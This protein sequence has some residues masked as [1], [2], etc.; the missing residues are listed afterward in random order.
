[1]CIIY[2]GEHCIFINLSPDYLSKF[3]VLYWRFR[4]KRLMYIKGTWTCLSYST[5]TTS[6]IPIVNFLC[7]HFVTNV[8]SQVQENTRELEQLLKEPFQPYCTLQAS[9]DQLDYYQPVFRKLH[10]SHDH[11]KS[12]GKQF[13]DLA[14]SAKRHSKPHEQA[15]K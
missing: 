1:M 14:A 7:V 12:H 11:C 15:S 13:L 6:S 8:A 2:P 10:E 9:R 5:Q 3:R 4:V